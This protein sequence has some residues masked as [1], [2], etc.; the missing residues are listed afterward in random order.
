MKKLYSPWMSVAHC[1]DLLGVSQSTIRR[2]IRAGQLD[3]VKGQKL[4]RIHTRDWRRY[5]AEH[6]PYVDLDSADERPGV[7]DQPDHQ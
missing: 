6:W 2:A 1:A 5:L 3:A 7:A 4:V